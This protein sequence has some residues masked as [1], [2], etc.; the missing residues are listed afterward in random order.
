[1]RRCFL[2]IDG[3]D[4]QMS[5]EFDMNKNKEKIDEFEVFIEENKSVRGAVMPILQEAQRIFGYIPKERVE[6]MSHRL[7]KHSS[8]I[9]GVATFYSQFTFVPKGKYAISVCLGTACYVNGANDILEE[10]EKQLKIKKGET[11]KDLMFSIVETRC[12]GECAMAPVVTVNDKV[13]P[14]FSVSDVDDL[15][16]Q[17]R[18][19][20]V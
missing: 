17:Y 16:T 10:F 15:L 9:Y 12:V 11:T 20:E 1:M 6:I 5:F 8:E 4:L 3:G 7:G 14:K 13:Y 18:E 19:M 2:L